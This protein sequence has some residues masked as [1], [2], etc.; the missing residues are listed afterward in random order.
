ML[1]RVHN[2][3]G[4]AGLIVAVVAL[5]AA[6]GGAAVAASGKLTSGQKKEVEKISK[7]VAKKVAKAGPVGPP[8]P[9]GDAGAKGDQGPKGEMGPEGKQGPKGDTGEAGMCSKAEPE[10]SLASGAT[11]TGA[12]SA[13][14]DA[15]SGTD[16]ATISFPVR[17]LPAP[18]TLY[19]GVFGTYTIGLEIKDGSV[20]KFGFSGFSEEELEKGEKAAKAACPGSFD[21][22]E[23]SS[24]FLCLYPGA[25]E[26]TIFGP[27]FSSTNTEAAH[28]FGISVP[29]KFQEEASETST[30]MQRGSWAVTG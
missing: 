11:L 5:I 27:N 15:P 3:L 28:E 16:L 2:K 29:F 26:G 1:S 8:G 10:C 21:T 6:L 9:K 17:V 7:K 22:P 23:A 18:T 30:A 13:V 25:K 24:G 19:I 4:T 20:G 14:A 12:W